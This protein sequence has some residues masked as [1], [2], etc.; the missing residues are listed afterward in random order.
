MRLDQNG[1]HFVDNISNIFLW[2]NIFIFL[3]IFPLKFVPKGLIEK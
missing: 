1:P 3:F 2:K